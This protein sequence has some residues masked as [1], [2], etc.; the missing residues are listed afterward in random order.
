MK[1]YLLSLC[2][3]V[4]PFL[5]FAQEVAEKG[6]DEKFN[7]SFKPISDAWGAI[8]FYPILSL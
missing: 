1:K 5:T 4:F 2:T 6:L 7:E 8:V 3:L